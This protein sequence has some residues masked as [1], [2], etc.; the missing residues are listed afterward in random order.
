MVHKI[1]G[2]LRETTGDAAGDEKLIR[3]VTDRPGHDR[4][5]AMDTSK[6]R[7]ELGWVPTIRFDEGIQRTIQ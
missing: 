1:I 6:I 2:I 3:H 7:A 4:R 5:Y